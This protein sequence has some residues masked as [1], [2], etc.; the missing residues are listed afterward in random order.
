MTSAARRLSPISPSLLGVERCVERDL[1]DGRERLRDGTALPC[2]LGRRLE[3]VGVE[4]G[5]GGADAERDLRDPG[6]GHEC[7][8]RP[9]SAAARAGC[10]P[11][12]D[13]ARAPSRS[14]RRAPPRS[15]PP[16]SSSRPRH[17]RLRAAQLTSSGPNAPE[18]TSSIVPAPLIRSPRHVTDARRSAAMSLSSLARLEYDAHANRCAR[19]DQGGERAAFVGL[20]V[21]PARALRRRSRRHARARRAR[22]RR[23]DALSPRP[24]PA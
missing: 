17:P 6:A 12:R 9:R 14:T 7:H 23:S 16:G 13:R 4:P 1:G 5:N 15:A 11:A 20:A 8:G 22:R 19:P 21:P 3:R 18:P 2:R 10:R 24:R